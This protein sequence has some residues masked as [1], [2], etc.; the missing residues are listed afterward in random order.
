MSGNNSCR[1]DLKTRDGI[2]FVELLKDLLIGMGGQNVKK[3]I[4]SGTNFYKFLL[5]LNLMFALD[6]G[7]LYRFE[8]FIYKKK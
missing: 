2:I 6:K 4:A 8:F 5:N 1:N 3:G 7:Y